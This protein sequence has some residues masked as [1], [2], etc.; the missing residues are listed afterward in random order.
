MAYIFLVLAMIVAEILAW[1][2]VGRMVG[3]GWYVFFWFIAAFMLGLSL[4]RASKAQLMPQLQQMQ[5]G[6]MTGTPPNMSVLGR[7]LAGVL[8]MIPGLITDVLAL[9][10]LLPPVQRKLQAT[11]MSA[12]QK[13]QNAMLNQMMGGAAND[14][15][16]FGMMGGAAGTGNPLADLM[17]QMQDMQGSG[18]SSTIIEGEA[19]EIK[20]ANKRLDAPKKPRS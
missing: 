5:M 18:R 9:L 6:M 17:R 2:M 4:L 12:L 8:L 11:V 3:S 16:P 13:R 15:N 19:E 10:V 7:A 14:A 1:I 20:P